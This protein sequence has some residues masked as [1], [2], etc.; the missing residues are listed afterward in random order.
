MGKECWLSS[1]TIAIPFNICSTP[2]ELKKTVCNLLGDSTPYHARHYRVPEAYHKPLRKEITRL[3]EEVGV[4][5]QVKQVKQPMWSSPT[6]TIPL[7]ITEFFKH[8]RH[9][10]LGN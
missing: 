9:I 4:L 8:F 1:S 6:I 7:G 3:E 2:F 5:K 10:L